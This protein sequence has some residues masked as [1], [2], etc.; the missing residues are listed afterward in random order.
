MGSQRT[1]PRF[2]QWIPTVLRISLEVKNQ[3]KKMDKSG[4]CLY[5]EKKAEGE[6]EAV[7]YVRFDIQNQVISRV[8]NDV[9]FQ[10]DVKVVERVVQEGLFYSQ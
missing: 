3:R 5:L 10:P 4:A 2:G 6:E 7:S 9:Y 1:H 8:E